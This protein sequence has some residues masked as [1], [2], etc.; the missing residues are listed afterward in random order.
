MTKKNS[1]IILLSDDEVANEHYRFT[2]ELAEIFRKAGVD[3]TTNE[4]ESGAFVHVSGAMTHRIVKEMHEKGYRLA[5]VGANDNDLQ[6]ATVTK[7]AYN[8]G[9]VT[10]DGWA[11]VGVDKDTGQNVFAKAHGVE[12]GK[13]TLTMKWQE[14]IDFAA[15]QNAHL[16]S[17]AELDLLQETLNKGLLKEA[18][19]VSGSFPSGWVW[20]SRRSPYGPEDVSARIQMLRDGDRSWGWK[21]GQAPAVLF[22]SEPSRP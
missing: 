20:G 19:D 13:S 3:T 17:D 14:A 15:G 5:I 9:D 12:K 11:Y 21:G 4:M 16:G 22:R 1:K 6:S 10:E 8:I 7:Q 2:Q 18:F